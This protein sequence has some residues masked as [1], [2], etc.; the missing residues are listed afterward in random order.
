SFPML[1]KYEI[2]ISMNQDTYEALLNVVRNLLPLNYPELCIVTDFETPLMNSVQTIM[3]ESKLMGYW[4]HYCEVVHQR[5]HSGE[6][7]YSCNVCGK[8]FVQSTSLVVHQRS[9][10]G[11]RPHS[12]NVCGKLFTIDSHLTAHLSRCGS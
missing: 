12:C 5:T 7:P 1:Q 6:R 11:E 3:H 10:T 4:F 2:L 9:H 8:S